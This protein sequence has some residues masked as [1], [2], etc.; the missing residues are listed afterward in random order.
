MLRSAVLVVPFSASLALAMA[1]ARL[2]GQRPQSDY[3]GN[4]ACV[5]CHKSIVES[6]AQTA[7][8]R[9]SGS[10][11]PGLVEGSY[12]HPIS[13]V[14]YR[15]HRHGTARGLC[16][17]GNGDEARRGAARALHHHPHSSATRQLVSELATSGC[18][19]R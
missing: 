18:V 4:D 16:E 2:A 7:M 17:T 14:S 12:R 1:S 11:L 5:P 13:G 6:Y 19:K 9:T 8:A 3:V 10:A 15:V